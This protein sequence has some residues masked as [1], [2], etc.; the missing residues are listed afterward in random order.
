MRLSPSIFFMLMA[1]NLLVDRPAQAIRIPDLLSN[2][3]YNYGIHEQGTDSAI[4]GEWAP[5][6]SHVFVVTYDEAGPDT[7]YA[8][9]FSLQG[10]SSSI[11]ARLGTYQLL[12]AP[13]TSLFV[14]ALDGDGRLVAQADGPP[15]FL[16]PDL[17]RL[18]EGYEII[19]LRQLETMGNRPETLLIGAYDFSSGERFAAID[20]DQ[21]PLP[22]DAFRMPI[23]GCP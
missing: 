18:P 9:R 3:G 5:A 2:H 13:T 22:D 16:R 11:L 19:D 21:V 20:G 15:L 10:A 7:R 17:L 8:G 1:E 23:N 4:Q 12:N 6:G 14:Q